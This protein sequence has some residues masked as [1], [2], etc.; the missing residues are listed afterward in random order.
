MEDDPISSSE[1]DTPSQP[2]PTPAESSRKYCVPGPRK[3]VNTRRHTLHYSSL[4]SGR[5]KEELLSTPRFTTSMKTKDQARKLLIEHDLLPPTW[6]DPDLPFLG[7]ALLHLEQSI[8]DIKAPAAEALCAIAIILNSYPHTSIPPLIPSS[9]TTV[10]TSTAIQTS[11]TPDQETNQT[12]APTETSL[13]DQISKIKLTIQELRKTAAANDT[14]T[15]LLTNTVMSTR[16]KLHSAA[17]VISNSANLLAN[18]VASHS[19]S[20]PSSSSSPPLPSPGHQNIAQVLQEIKTLIRDRP[21]SAPSYKNALLRAPS[22]KQVPSYPPPQEQARANA[23][24]KERQ[25][26]IDLDDSHPIKK[27]IHTN[28]EMLTLFQAAISETK[29]DDS[30]D[31]KLQSLKL[32]KNGG[33]L[34]EFTNKEA[35]SWLKHGDRRERF[36]NA[37]GGKLTIKDRLF[38]IVVQFIPISTSLEDNGTLRNIEEDNNIPESS[39]T[40][41]RWIKPINKR[42]PFQRFAHAILS[43]SSPTVANHLIKQGINVNRENLRAHKDKKEPL[44]CLKCQKWGHI[45]RTCKAETDTCGTCADNHRSSA[46]PSEKPPFCVSC[47]VTDHPSSSR[48][49]PVFIQKCHDLNARTPE[50]IMPYFP[51]EEEWTQDLLLPKITKPIVPTRP[52]Q[53]PNPTS[54]PNPT[55]H[56]EIQTTIDKY[57]TRQS[58]RPRA[59]TASQDA[60]SSTPL[61]STAP[62]PQAS[63]STDANSNDLWSGDSAAHSD[64]EPPQ[65]APPLRFPTLSPLLPPPPPLPLAK[66]PPTSQHSVD[67]TPPSSPS[68]L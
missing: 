2:R 11:P 12:T 4:N 40:S 66:P 17:Q 53:P 23:A 49:C 56:R 54:T 45:T 36:V 63:Q 24:I 29:E 65:E 25:I 58:Q 57:T 64:P 38:N 30:P 5:T 8:S 43:I 34:L 62:L 47:N 19:T 61:A 14:T 27:Q 67:D 7:T 21:A 39:I 35:V 51:T 13:A 37:T 42:S 33:I 68:S 60:R 9:V 55:A 59:P 48:K 52:P 32:L 44:R 3:T 41:A 18:N 50:N 26:L 6:Q 10:F 15:N 31:M 16:D 20:P 28:D 22:S 46:C 1:E